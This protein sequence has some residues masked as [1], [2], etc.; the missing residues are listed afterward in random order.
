MTDVRYLRRPEGRIA[1]D[2]WDGD[3]PLVICASGM[4]EL[5]QSYRLL[6]PKLVEAG[7][8]VAVMDIR[9]HGDSDASF[10][11]YDDVAL[12]SDLLA[13]M[14]ELGGSAYLVGNSMGAGAAV[15]AAA[16]APA[17]VRGLALLG[18]FVRNPA[19]AAVLNLLFRIML[20]RP[21][22]P[23][24]FLGYYPK[25]LPGTKPEGYEQH[26]A[27]VRDNLRRPGHWRAFV[28]TT[29]TSHEPARRRLP[30]VSA[31]AVVV[32]GA[33]DVDW[34]DPAAEAHWIG[35]QL[36]AEV[37]LAPGVGHFPQ[38]QAPDAVAAVVTR[39]VERVR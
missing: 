6:A 37:V 2:L 22:G 16:D 21:W 11:A 26:L 29:R 36:G 17:K 20:V 23:A 18:P 25:W 14:D 12:A 19:G 30:E 10:S 15:I 33:A 32:M 27:R 13:L 39:L 38:A 9:G 35:E 31:P 5:R 28:R 24:A 1:Y 4:G 8:R 3:G 7:Y 34:K